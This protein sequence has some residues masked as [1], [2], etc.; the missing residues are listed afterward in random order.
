ILAFGLVAWL[1][2]RRR[3]AT[4]PAA[5][6][7]SA[8]A[9][10]E[11]AA[12]LVAIVCPGCGKK[13]RARATLAGKKG[14]CVQCAS[15]IPVPEAGPDESTRTTTSPHDRRGPASRSRPLPRAEVHVT[16]EPMALPRDGGRAFP[17]Y[18]VMFLVTGVFACSIYANLSFTVATKAD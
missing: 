1:V 13:M 6:Q 17:I 9:A 3:R 2:V 14:K 8:Q 15:P 10:A 11:P 5:P 12:P 16:G 4:Q 7:P 18:S